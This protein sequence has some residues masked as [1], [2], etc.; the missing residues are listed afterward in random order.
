M[1]KIKATSKKKAE[2]LDTVNS[3]SK[4]TIEEETP[5]FNKYYKN[6]TFSEFNKNFWDSYRAT[7]AKQIEDFDDEDDDDDGEASFSSKANR[8]AIREI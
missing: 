5:V 1:K 6:F 8:K 7:A 3:T 2:L 4:I